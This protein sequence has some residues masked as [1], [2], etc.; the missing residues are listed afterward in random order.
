MTTMKTLYFLAI[1]GAVSMLSA[2]ASGPATMSSEEC[3][4]ADWRAVGREDGLR[5]APMEALGARVEQCSQTQASVDV[6]AYRAGRLEGLT[7]FCTEENGYDFGYRGG[8]Y[9]GVCPEEAEE[10]FIAGYQDGIT[11]YKL[12]QDVKETER[13]LR[14]MERDMDRKQ[15]ELKSFERRVSSGQLTPPEQAR[16]RNELRMLAHD[17]RQL[18]E[19][20]LR[21]QVELAEREKALETYEKRRGL[22]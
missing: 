7:E 20:R 9:H 6:V 10:D 8:D 12:K 2:C 19:L 5:G 21:L 16:A 14:K 4:N 13:E 18:Q 1:L 3:Q 17:I 15:I 22:E 11:M